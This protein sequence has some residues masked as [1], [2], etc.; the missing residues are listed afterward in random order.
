MHFTK[1]IAIFISGKLALPMVDTL[2]TIAPGQGHSVV[3]LV[4]E[5]VPISPG[6]AGLQPRAPRDIQAE[7]EN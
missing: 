7:T 1:A 5:T 3:L 6:S 4:Q 2:M